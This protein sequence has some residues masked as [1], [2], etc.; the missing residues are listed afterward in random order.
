MLKV[1]M[2]FSQ[3][4]LMHLTVEFL[5]NVTEA[6]TRKNR[7]SCFI[8]IAVKWMNYSKCL[9]PTSYTA[10]LVGKEKEDMAQ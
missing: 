1:S 7:K 8:Y 2:I 6:K 10:Q 9:F 4:I 3:N 5:Q